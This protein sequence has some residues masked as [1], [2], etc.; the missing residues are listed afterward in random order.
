MN[1]SLKKR[2]SFEQQCSIKIIEPDMAEKKVRKKKKNLTNIV[3][4]KVKIMET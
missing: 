2:K 1:P 3:K 4:K